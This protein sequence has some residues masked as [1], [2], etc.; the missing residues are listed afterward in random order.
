[1]SEEPLYSAPNENKTFAV[2]VGDHAVRAGEDEGVCA[3]ARFLIPAI[4]RVLPC[5]IQ[6]FRITRLH[7]IQSGVPHPAFRIN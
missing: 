1:M 6:S 2:G 7:C 4:R 3:H 5:A